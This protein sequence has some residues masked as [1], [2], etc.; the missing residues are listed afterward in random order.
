[1]TLLSSLKIHRPISPHRKVTLNS[2]VHVTSNA[3]IK[4]TTNFHLSRASNF[5]VCIRSAV[6]ANVTT[7]CDSAFSVNGDISIT[8]DNRVS[9]PNDFAYFCTIC[10]NLLESTRSVIRMNAFISRCV[11]KLLNMTRFGFHNLI[12]W[13]LSSI[14]YL[15]LTKVAFIKCHWDINSSLRIL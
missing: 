7:D 13:I 8:V 9:I 4:V 5:N 10:I 3:N 14:W 12:I 2:N 15:R 11:I 6:N 1:M